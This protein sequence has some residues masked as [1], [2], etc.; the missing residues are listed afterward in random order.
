MEGHET[1][2]INQAFLAVMHAVGTVKA[3]EVTAIT[4][5]CT[6]SRI[7]LSSSIVAKQ[8]P[9][10]RVPTG[11]PFL[12]DSEL[13]ALSL[14]GFLQVLSF[15]ISFTRIVVLYISLSFNIFREGLG[16]VGFWVF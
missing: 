7:M 16:V 15:S 14:F 9:K 5:V 2:M 8:L 13:G 11:K 12:H 6:G 10:I 1:M 4:T 3:G